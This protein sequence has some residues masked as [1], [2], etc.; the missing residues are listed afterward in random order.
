MIE[1]IYLHVGPHKTGSTT[2]QES[3]GNNRELLLQHGYLY[4]CFQLN[5][6]LEFNHSTPLKNRFY[7]DDEKNAFAIPGTFIS[8]KE[9]QEW[10]QAFDEQ[11]K[12]QLNQFS[13]KYLIFSGEYLCKLSIAHFIQ[14]KR[15]LIDTTNEKVNFKI[16]LLTRNPVDLFQSDLIEKIKHG[17]TLHKA[18]QSNLSKYVCFFKDLIYTLEQVFEPSNIIVYRFED[19]IRH[20]GG[21]AAA[22]LQKLGVNEQLLSHFSNEQYNPSLSHEAATILSAINDKIPTQEGVP[23]IL[24]SGIIWPLIKLKGQKYVLTKDLQRKIWN[25]SNEDVNGICE[26]F[27]LPGYI[28]QEKELPPI[29]ELWSSETLNNLHAVFMSASE[30]LKLIILEVLTQELTNSHNDVSKIQ[31]D[32]ILK[33]IAESTSYIPI[34]GK[35]KTYDFILKN[36]GYWKGISA[37]KHCLIDN[38][39]CLI[40]KKWRAFSINL[41]TLAE[42]KTPKHDIASVLFKNSYLH[43]ISIGRDP[44]FLIENP[45]PDRKIKC[46]SIVLSVPENTVCQVFFTNALNEA[47]SESKSLCYF[48]IGG[49]NKAY[50]EFPSLEMIVKIRIDPGQVAGE[51]CLHSVKI[52][53]K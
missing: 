50:F 26:A 16:L 2:I 36:M 32:R 3:L 51:Y 24:S 28:Y 17:F 29:S 40:L 10:K 39:I 11:F 38:M 22:F 53:T 37:I 25:L 13:G 42:E 7:R 18:T 31:K 52:E 41:R 14:L 35:V 44:W 27:S 45:A 6:H 12:L 23:Y 15:Y 21:P 9:Y 19:S 1:T 43:F 47:F 4:P 33:F 20:P 5:G 46:L 30:E 34:L 48:A 49:K 8:I